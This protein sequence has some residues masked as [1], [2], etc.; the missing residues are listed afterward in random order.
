M[1]LVAEITRSDGTKIRLSLREAAAL[2]LILESPK[3]VELREG[4]FKSYMDV[5]G[6]DR[7]EA[8]QVVGPM[9]LDGFVKRARE[10]AKQ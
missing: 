2:K 8:E 6:V 7:K 9:L 5:A 1:S 10:M 4:L 3:A